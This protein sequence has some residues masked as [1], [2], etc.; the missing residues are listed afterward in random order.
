MDSSSLT[1]PAG[2][3]LEP[4]SVPPP[5]Q[6]AFDSFGE[7]QLKHRGL[8]P[9]SV[10][11]YTR[12]LRDFAEHLSSS[13]DVAD[14][15]QITIAHV[16]D[17]LVRQAHP[18]GHHYARQATSTL[19]VFLR[20]LALGGQVAA[21]FAGQVPST[22]VYALAGLPRGIGWDDVLGVLAAMPRD[23]VGS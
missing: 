8:S 6:H 7:F 22:R 9:D 21:E 23:E 1:L 20:Y 4:P 18:R 11:N 16:D 5:W 12:L 14:P 17:F 15:S 3:R 10:R 13:A 2:A 19:R